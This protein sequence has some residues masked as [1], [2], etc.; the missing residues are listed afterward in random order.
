MRKTALAMLLAGIMAPAVASAQLDAGVDGM[1]GA[2]TAVDDQATGGH[3]GSSSDQHGN[4]GD[5]GRTGKEEDAGASPT[6]SGQEGRSGQ[7]PL[8]G[9][10][11]Q[12][13]G[14]PS[15]YTGGGPPPP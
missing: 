13:K 6:N 1:Y 12:G 4:M 3:T 2:P 8:P 9:P 5:T 15:P 7:R 11:P 10:A 14:T